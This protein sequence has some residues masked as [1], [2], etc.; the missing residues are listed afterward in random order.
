MDIRR[1]LTV[2]W[3]TN[4]PRATGRVTRHD[5]KGLNPDGWLVRLRERRRHRI[6]WRPRCESGAP[7]QRA[8]DEQMA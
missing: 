2:F 5:L 6:Q 1:V 7:R 8:R 3:G 4:V